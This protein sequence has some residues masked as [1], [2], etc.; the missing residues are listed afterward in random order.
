MY[1]QIISNSRLEV[2]FIQLKK[3]KKK[4]TQLTHKEVG[5]LLKTVCWLCQTLTQSKDLLIIV[6]NM[7]LINI[8]LIQS[9]FYF[10]LI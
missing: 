8:F 2:G 9:I 4:K 7:T 1:Q 3:E 5:D 6:P 10:N